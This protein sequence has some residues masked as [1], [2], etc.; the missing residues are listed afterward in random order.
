MPSKRR[1]P[2]IVIG[3]TEHTTKEVSR[4]RK[5]YKEADVILTERALYDVQDIGERNPNYVKTIDILTEIFLILSL[6]PVL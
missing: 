1:K 2:G 5:Q 6:L 3:F 4:L